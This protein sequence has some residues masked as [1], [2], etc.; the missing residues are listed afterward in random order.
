M[1]KKYFLNVV[2]SR[3]N[4]AINCTKLHIK[5]SMKTAFMWSTSLSEKIVENLRFFS[6]KNILFLRIIIIRYFPIFLNNATRCR[7]HVY[8]T[9]EHNSAETEQEY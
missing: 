3:I 4:Q 5:L 2:T 6:F 7:F 9:Q 8:Y 1:R